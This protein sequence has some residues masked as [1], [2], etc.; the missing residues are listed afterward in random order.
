MKMLGT[1][2]MAF[3]AKGNGPKANRNN[4]GR[5]AKKGYHP[6]QNGRPKAGIGKKQ[7][8]KG[9]GG[10]NIARVKCYNCGKKGYDARD[11]PESKKV[12]SST[13]LLSYMYAPMH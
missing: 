13:V 7:K 5:Q 1:S 3:V 6:L 10:I 11:C 12:L 2:R 8:A 9:N 4:R